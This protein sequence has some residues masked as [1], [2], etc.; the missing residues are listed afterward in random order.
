MRQ[1]LTRTAGD[2]G[3]LVIELVAGEHPDTLYRKSKPT[4]VEILADGVS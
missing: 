2:H 4:V 3:D 1:D